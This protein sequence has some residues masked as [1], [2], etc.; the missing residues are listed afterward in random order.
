MR[1]YLILLIVFLILIGGM[2]AL[3]V[4]NSKDKKVIQGDEKLIN[5]LEDTL[6][7]N[8]ENY[9][10][11]VEGKVETI[12]GEE[13]V[14]IKVRIQK[15]HEATVMR[16]F[17]ERY[18]KVERDSFSML[19]PIPKEGL[20]SEIDKLK[21]SCAFLVCIEGNEVKTREI[22]IYII[23]EEDMFVYFWG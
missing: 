6:G 14:E 10:E 15:E 21:L 8:I 12:N 2:I 18:I 17:E 5:C 11:C 3:I 16:L 9:I 20:I 19:P 22:Y 13:V 23:D 4:Y 1:K 7:I